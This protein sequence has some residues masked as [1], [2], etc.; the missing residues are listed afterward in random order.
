MDNWKIENKK[1]VP[2]SGARKEAEM[3][4]RLL[5]VTPLLG[6]HATKQAV[7]DRIKSVSLIYT[8]AHGIAERGE[9][10]LAHPGLYYWDSSR[11]RLSV[12]NF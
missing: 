4:G 12:E 7:L 5:G 2:L 1:F 11:R 6:Q 3:I 9:S 8:A 10:A